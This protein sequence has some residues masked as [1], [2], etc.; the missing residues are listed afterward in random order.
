MDNIDNSDLEPKFASHKDKTITS[1][2]CAQGWRR[3]RWQRS[4]SNQGPRKACCMRRNQ[5][6][7]GADQHQRK[8]RN[9]QIR[10]PSVSSA[11]RIRRGP[12]K[13]SMEPGAK[14]PWRENDRDVRSCMWMGLE[15]RRSGRHG[16]GKGRQAPR[17]AL[18]LAQELDDIIQEG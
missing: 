2:D 16:P 6:I 3:Q 11:C 8:E 12:D 5:Q 18:A 7:F 10:S 15:R 1:R 4:G 13:L 9:A 17:Q 14:R